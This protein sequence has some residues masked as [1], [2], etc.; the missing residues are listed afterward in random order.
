M[1]SRETLIRLKRF[2]VDERRRHVVQIESMIADF[3]RM[4]TDLD[5]EILT[6]QD[7]AGIDDPG[8]FAYP[9]YA[10]AAMTRR[11]NLRRSADELRAQLDD[12]RAQLG[13]A[14]EE[15]KK[16][17]ILEERD[18]ERER[19]VEA[20]REQVELDRIGAQLRHA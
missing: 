17:E 12:A 16:V 13:E 19:L 18:Q 2:Q 5:R 9:T 7:R 15:L 11:D 1:K 20:A 3:E 8:H 10:K 4:A 6:E 14:F